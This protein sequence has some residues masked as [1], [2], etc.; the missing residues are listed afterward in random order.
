ME[1]RGN[2]IDAPLHG[3]VSQLYVAVGDTVVVG[4]PVL[5]MEAMK[6]IHTLGA[7]AAGTIAAIRC[8]VGETVP[9]GTVLVEI[10]LKN[11]EEVA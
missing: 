3:M 6:L 5:Q 11:T 4:T 8:V 10:T 9:A 2:L 1:Q 7:P